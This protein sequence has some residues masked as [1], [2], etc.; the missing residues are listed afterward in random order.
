MLAK[1]MAVERLG[2][3]RL[4][5]LAFSVHGYRPVAI[6]IVTLMSTTAAMRS[7]P[8]VYE[9][10]FPHLTVRASPVSR[11]APSRLRFRG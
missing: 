4:A 10:L 11:N 7:V 3:A 1:R 5:H 2:I 8:E 6:G 9:K